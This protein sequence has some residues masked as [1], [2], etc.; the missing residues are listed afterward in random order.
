MDVTVY[1]KPNCPQC[2][3]TKRLLDRDHVTY[4]EV[5]IGGKERQMFLDLGFMSAPV[6]VVDQPVA[7]GAG[8]K[9]F[10]ETGV[11]WAGLNPDAISQLV[12]AHQEA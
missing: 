4:R 5:E 3:Q 1:T 2:V 7:T 6:V 12:K 11:A 10:G 8:V 9:E